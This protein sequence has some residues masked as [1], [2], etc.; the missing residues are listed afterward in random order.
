MPERVVATDTEHL[1]RLI[2]LALRKDGLA[3]SLNHI[4]VSNVTSFD[5]LF[6]YSDF[7]GDVSEWDVSAG[8]SFRKMFQSSRFNGD[9]SRWNME[10][11]QD[12]SHMFDDAWFTGD[13]SQWNVANVRAMNGMFKNSPFNGDLSRWDVRALSDA[14]EMFAESKFTGDLSQWR[15]PELKNAKDMFAHSQFNGDVSQWNPKNLKSA[16][17]M[18]NSKLFQG[19]LSDW[20]LAPYCETARMLNAAYSGGLPCPQEDVK[21]H[22]YR[23]MMASENALHAYF[24]RTPLSMAHAEM[25]VHD[26]LACPWA[27]PE[28]AEWTDNFVRMGKSMGMAHDEMVLAFLSAP[29]EPQRSPK[30]ARSVPAARSCP[31]FSN[32]LEPSS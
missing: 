18:F 32:A 15:L 14:K 10:K 30:D 31:I 19:D 5:R 20:T 8:E 22:S 12:L 23:A 17:G 4:D 7:V 26:V 27:S 13:I 21:A 3:C 1:T 25:L 2:Y 29:K 28:L 11:A 9:I 16:G 6:T 24:A